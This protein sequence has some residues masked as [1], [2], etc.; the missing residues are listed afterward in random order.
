MKRVILPFIFIVI[1]I[2][3]ILF[4]F[5]VFPVLNIGLGYAAKTT[6]SSVFVSGRKLDSVINED[7][8]NSA[9]SF[10][11]VSVNENNKSATASFLGLKRKA[12]YRDGVGCTLVAKN[13][14]D[15]SI[16]LPPIKK[17]KKLHDDFW[18]IEKPAYDS[19]FATINFEQ[20]NKAFN[21]A[22][23]EKNTDSPRN[24][25]AA[26]VVHKGKLLKEQYAKDFTA[27]TPLL[28]WSMT[29]SVINALCG[30]LVK[31]GKMALK[32]PTNFTEW[33]DD[34]RTQITLNHLLQMNSGLYFKEDY[35][36]ASSVNEMLWLN[37]NCAKYAIN[38]KL[39]HQPGTFWNYASGTSNI[40][41]YL[42]KTKFDS[43]QAYLEFPHKKL[44]EPL[45][46]SSA[47]LE[48]DN[49]NTYIGSSFM[50]ATGRDWAK[51]GMLYL[52]NGFWNGE[53]ILPGGWVKYS[54]KRN[55]V[56]EYGTYAAHFWKNA[57]EPTTD[58]ENKKYWPNLP[59]DMYY[60][61]GYEGQNLVIIPS[62]ELV[63]VRLGQTQKRKSWDMGLFVG[64][65]LKAL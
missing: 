36:I 47:I 39:A 50:Y 64:E 2:V 65:I 38:Q 63:I 61:S 12:I 32:E 14:F 29:K 24:T 35:S 30:I 62:K 10:A 34:H 7:I 25:R 52:Q 16:A 8:K 11:T 1:L 49:N 42:I 5:K 20:L 55:E 41:S 33:A 51:F 53:Q 56:S 28:G 59:D 22:F 13:N 17:I 6:C 54:S 46:M 31:E 58:L 15:D 48:V 23:E 40:I 44:F 27:K 21:Y 45:G 4:Y 18:Q 3:G 9:T 26:L 19:L 57:T 43:E 37:G 60:A